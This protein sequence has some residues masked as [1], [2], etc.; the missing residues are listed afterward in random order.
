MEALPFQRGYSTVVAW[1]SYCAEECYYCF[2]VEMVI[3]LLDLV[4]YRFSVA[5]P[6]LGIE[7]R[8]HTTRARC[9]QNDPTD[10][11]IYRFSAILSLGARLLV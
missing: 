11:P 5:C 10:R 7:V 4:R 1:K 3:D 2:S 6:R 9:G 8:G